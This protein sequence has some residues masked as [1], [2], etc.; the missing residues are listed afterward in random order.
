LGVA[1]CPRARI[2]AIS[3]FNPAFEWLRALIGALKA[4][5]Y[6]QGSRL[7]GTNLHLSL[8]S[9]LSSRR[10]E[11]QNRVFRAGGQLKVASTPTA[12]ASTPAAATTS[13]TPTTAATA[14]ACTTAV[15]ATPA[16]GPAPATTASAIVGL[17]TRF[18]HYDS[19]AHYIFSIERGDSL[20]QF[21][22]VSNFYEAEPT[23]LTG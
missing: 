3:F 5:S 9:F 20:L 2:R 6:R 21:R 7:T 18:V 4:N 11:N 23:R 12:T 10:F 19:P 16:A 15:A 1:S 8:F 17:R 22:V 14:T 13:T